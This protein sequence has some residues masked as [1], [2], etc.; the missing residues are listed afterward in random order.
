MNNKNLILSDRYE[1][2]RPLGQG[3]CGSVFLVRQQSLEQYRAMKRFPKNTSA[4][5]L[6]AISE[7]QILKSVQHPGIPT[8]YDFEEDESF[9]YLVEEY[10]QGDSLEEFLLHQQSISQN[11]FLYFCEQL[12]DI[13]AYLHTLR[14]SPILYQDLKPE[15]IIVCGTQLKL[16]DF[17]VASFAAISGKDFNHFGNVDF[18][19]PELISGKPVTLRSDIYSIG[20][21]MEYMMPY[22]D[23]AT[24]RSIYPKI[25]KAISADPDLRYESPQALY[26]ALKEVIETTGR[27]HLRQTIAVVGN[28]SGCGATHI[29]IA[30][31]TTL[32][33]LGISAVYQEKNWSNDLRKTVAQ[34]KHVWE[35]NGC[36]FYR[37]FTGFP[38]YDSGIE[39]PEPVAQIMVNDYGCDSLRMYEL[40][41]GPPELDAEW[42]DRGIDGVYRFLNKV[43][44]LVMDSK[45]KNVSATKEMI[46]IRNKMV[47]DITTRLESFS[48]N[49]VISGFM[50]YN[51]KLNE[52][53]KKA[54]GVDKE[55]LS[56]LAVLLAP[57]APHMAEE[58][59]Q[60]LGHEGTV[61]NAGW[62]TYDE[63]AMKDD[64]VEIAVQINGKTR[65]VVTLA[66]DVSKEDAIAK[67]K[68]AVADKLTGMIV[69]EIYVPGRIINIVQK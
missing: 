57:F 36:F 43:W 4:Q 27:T 49:T 56:T 63:E 60:Q 61:F 69:K 55:T 40:F 19:A 32:N 66:A 67:G 15:H 37:N 23:A 17:S 45:D 22:L 1:L 35:K 2:I 24:N 14:P 51:N 12:C 39:I 48:L 25:Q 47:Y 52:I 38:K 13:F 6:F 16:I 7:A 65:A 10:I 59:W 41:V 68:E 11:Q 26:S 9:Y 28:H 20:K 50:E 64:E 54:G 62:P 8:I 18:S 30:L 42:D 46:K 29:A 33:Y 3:E 58:L 34:L 21:I 44:N 5:P 31:V 53:A